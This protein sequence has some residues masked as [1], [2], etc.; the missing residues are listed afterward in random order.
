MILATHTQMKYY[1]GCADPFAAFLLLRSL[2]TFTL[3]VDRQNASA[4]ALAEHLEHH[5]KVW[6]VFYPGLASHPQ[7]AIALRQMA[8]HGSGGFGGMVTIECAEE[9]VPL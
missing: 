4:L 6:R 8:T 9:Y 3:R 1:G 2:K 7:H 5:P